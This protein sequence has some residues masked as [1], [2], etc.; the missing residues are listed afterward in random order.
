MG[1]Q[2]RSQLFVALGFTLG[3]TLEVCGI[4]A[5]LS[6]KRIQGLLKVLR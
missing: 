3:F 2:W 4:A 1:D 6:I 5:E